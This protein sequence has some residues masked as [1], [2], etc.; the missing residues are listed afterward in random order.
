MGLSLF[1]IRWSYRQ[2]DQREDWVRRSDLAM[3]EVGQELGLGFVA[4]EINEHPVMGSMTSFGQLHGQLY[5]TSVELVVAWEDMGDADIRFWTELRAVLPPRA[6]QIDPNRLNAFATKI[7]AGARMRAD[8]GR[9]LLAPFVP[10][11]T[12][13]SYKFSIET[14]AGTLSRLLGELANFATTFAPPRGYRD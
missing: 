5:G 9:L 6:A 14:N 12:S 1:M 13:S 4:G 11:H 3:Q 8:G 2:Q 10:E 7:Q